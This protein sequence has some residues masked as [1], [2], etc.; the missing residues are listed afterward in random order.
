MYRRGED[1]GESRRVYAEEARSDNFDNQR[2]LNYIDKATAGPNL[3]AEYAPL[4]QQELWA[5]ISFGYR[6]ID[7]AAKWKWWEAYIRTHSEG[8]SAPLMHRTE[9]MCS[10][11]M[12][13]FEYRGLPCIVVPLYR[14]RRVALAQGIV[15]FQHAGG[16]AGIHRDLH[17]VR[18]GPSYEMPEGIRGLGV[19]LLAAACQSMDID[20]LFASP[21]DFFKN[22]VLLFLDRNRVRHWLGNDCN[23]C[24]GG[25]GI[26][27]TKHRDYP[28]WCPPP[29]HRIYHAR[30]RCNPTDFAKGPR[31]D[32][33]RFVADEPRMIPWWDLIHQRW[34][35]F[36]R[37]A[38]LDAY[39]DAFFPYNFL[40]QM[41][42]E[43]MIIID[44]GDMATYSP[45]PAA[46]GPEPEDTFYRSLD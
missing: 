26:D 43:G 35:D 44:A 14:H 36:P 5:Q 33:G 19:S 3:F 4:A 22:M 15:R 39:V 38:A 37:P 20:L 9:G 42:G 10:L 29:E 30:L 12:C 17:G 6:R 25:N 46:P 21:I 28:A 45:L 41:A 34:I 24:G 32:L 16:F 13:F 23:I 11:Y 8:A 31:V 1:Y 18:K 27:I 40:Q 7:T 2:A